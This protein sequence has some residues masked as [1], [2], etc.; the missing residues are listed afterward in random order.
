MMKMTARSLALLVALVLPVEVLAQVPP[1]TQY[2]LTRTSP[3][4]VQ[5]S[6]IQKTAMTCGLPRA[7]PAGTGFRINDPLNDALDCELLGTAGGVLVPGGGVYTIAAGSADGLW[8]GEVPASNILSPTSP[9]NPRTRPGA[10]LEVSGPV[11]R[12]FPFPVNGE[13]IDVAT[14]EVGGLPVHIG[15]YSLTTS[16]YSVKPGDRVTLSFWR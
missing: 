14:L 15:A 10:L 2:R 6:V 13:M 16:T 5:S 7:I 12:R 1:T 4:P 9:T 3:L 11:L 8:S